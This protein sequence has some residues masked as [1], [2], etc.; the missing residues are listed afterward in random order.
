MGLVARMVLQVVQVRVKEQGRRRLLLDAP[1]LS[2]IV[3]V[4][5]PLL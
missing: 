5:P 2:T 4:L 1:A 3:L